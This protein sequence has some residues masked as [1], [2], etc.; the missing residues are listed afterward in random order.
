M[1]YLLLVMVLLLTGCQTTMNR[2]DNGTTGSLGQEQSLDSPANT[3]IQLARE[4]L[5]LGDYST[6]LMKAKKAVARDPK[7]SNAHLMLAL[8][9]ERLNEKAL[10]NAAYR[11]ALQIDSRNS[12]ALNAYGVYLCQLDEYDRSLTFFER[13]VEN[14]LYPTPWAAL[15]NA[16][17]CAMKKGDKE[18]AEGYFARALKE[19]KNFAPA[20]L[21]MAELN[22]EQKNYLSVRAF[23]QRYREV[24]QPTPGMLYMSILTERQLGDKNRARSDELLLFSEFPESDEAR[25]LKKN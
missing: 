20:L 18:K 19:K 4:Y 6:A 23:I 16:G 17:F 5:R 11:K 9:Y 7:N 24:A 10:A 3:Y 22:F 14:P 1:K 12:F 25:K 21:H 15:T 8:V 13:A 2:D